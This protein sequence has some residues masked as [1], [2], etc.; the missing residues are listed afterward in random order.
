MLFGGILAF[1]EKKLQE[2][3]STIYYSSQ[4][5]LDLGKFPF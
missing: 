4:E 5:F 2:L 3:K 1:L